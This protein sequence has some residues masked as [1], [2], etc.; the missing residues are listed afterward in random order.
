LELHKELLM[1]VV[2][3]TQQDHLSFF[4]KK[5]HFRQN[6]SQWIWD[7]QGIQQD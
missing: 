7:Q 2:R 5:R 1:I 6:C 3:M 4:E